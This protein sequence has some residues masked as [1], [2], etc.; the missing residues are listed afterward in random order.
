M[1]PP[2]LQM[3][4][5]SLVSAGKFPMRT[6]GFPMIHGARVTGTHGMGVKTPSL[7]AV[8]AI[9]VGLAG[10]LHAPKGNMLT[11][12]L[13]SMIVAAGSI[14]STLF[15]GRTTRD[16]G[17]AP[18]EHCSMAPAVTRKPIYITIDDAHATRAR[19]AS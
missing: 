13:L 7:A 16:D 15:R 5:L 8:A 19:H 11:I 1:T 4:L 3:S 18:N 6:V 10:E 14:P 12:G 9:T 17:A 2:Q